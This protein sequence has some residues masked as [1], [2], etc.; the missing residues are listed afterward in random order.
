MS[1]TTTITGLARSVGT[2]IGASLVFL[3]LATPSTMAIAGTSLFGMLTQP[4]NQLASPVEIDPTTGMT[5]SLAP[6]KSYGGTSFYMAFSPATNDLYFGADPSAPNALPFLV[7]KNVSTLQETFLQVDPGSNNILEGLTV[8]PTTGKLFGMLTQPGN[9]LASPVEIDPTTGMTTSLAPG[10]SYGGTSFYMAFSPAT[11]DLYFGADPSAP[12]ALPFLV[13]KNVST[14]QETFLQVDPGSNNILEG[15]TVD[16]TT[17]KLF[18]MLTQPGNQLA[19]PVEIDPTTGMTTSLA[20]GESYGGTSFYMAFSPA[21]NDLYFGA[22]PSAPNALPFLVE[23]NVSTLQETFLQVDP[24]SNNILEGL[25]VGDVGS[26][27][28]VPEPSSALLLIS[29]CFG[30]V[31]IGR[32]R[33]GA[34]SSQ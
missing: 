12:N 15:L 17:G 27:A 2:F 4:G 26:V 10:E 18:G 33:T 24:G 1:S 21:T 16:P 23:K 8:D 5:T 20:P 30:F 11:N 32:R 28:S 6:G 29:C 9:Q 13:E 7:E 3:G 14:L 34:V 19:S 25:T 22:D 31:A